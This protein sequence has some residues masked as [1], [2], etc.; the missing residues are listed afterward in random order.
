[1]IKRVW[2]FIGGEFCEPN[3]K[4]SQGDIFIAVD[5]GIRHCESMELIPDIHIGDFDSS[6]V[7]EKYP[8]CKIIKFPSDKKQTDF[9][10][11]LELATQEYPKAELHI[12]GSYGGEEDHAF[13]SLLSLKK[14]KLPVYLWQKNSLVFSAY[15]ANQIE[16]SAKIGEKVSVFALE[17]LEGLTYSG[18]RWTLNNATL[19][20][21]AT[22]ASRNELSEQIAKISW[23]KGQALIFLPKTAVVSNEQ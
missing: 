7:S 10:L 14:T 1:M 8:K 16:F 11:A 18:L 9:E 2:I 5:S 19:V 23:S 15:G 13:A 22:S 17:T 20:A 4:P 3:L 12:I 6:Q 21:F